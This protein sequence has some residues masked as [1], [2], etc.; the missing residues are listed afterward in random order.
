[1]HI[2]IAQCVSIIFREDFCDLYMCGGCLHVSVCLSR[3]PL[4]L[5]IDTF[6]IL[7]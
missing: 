4:Y 7:V 2:Y 1:M 5:N 3:M 6:D